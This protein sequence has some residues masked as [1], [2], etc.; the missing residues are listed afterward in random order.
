MLIEKLFIDIPTV[1]VMAL[2]QVESGYNHK[3]IGD[4]GA[5]HGILQIHKI[6]VDDVNRIYYSDGID[7]YTYEDRMSPTKSMEMCNLYLKHWGHSYFKKTG[8]LPTQETLAR[9]WNGGPN[10]WR[11]DATL[12]YWAKVQQALCTSKN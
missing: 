4:N 1:L 9:I 5:A 3:A 6:V 10:G 8:E 2:C 7:A 11:K 12:K